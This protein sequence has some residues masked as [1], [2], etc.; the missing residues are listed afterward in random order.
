MQRQNAGVLTVSTSLD[1]AAK[2]CIASLALL[3]HILASIRG[4]RRRC[5]TWLL[6]ARTST[7]RCGTV[8]AIGR[9]SRRRGFARSRFL[10]SAARSCSPAAN[11]LQWPADVLKWPLP[12]LEDQSKAWERWFALA[13]VVPAEQLPGPVLNRTSM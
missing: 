13:G 10:R 7:L 4:F 8:M 9:V 2:W 12:R 6:P 3:R 5:I 1:F 11:R